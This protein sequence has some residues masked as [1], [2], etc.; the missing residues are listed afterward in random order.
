MAMSR[1]LKHD[2]ELFVE[3]EIEDYKDSI[4]RQSLLRVGDQAIQ[5]LRSKGITELRELDV[6]I[7]VD[8]IIVRRLRLPSFKKW[9]LEHGL[10]QI[11]TSALL[12]SNGNPIGESS[13]PQI[14]QL[15]V[16]ATL[17]DLMA[18][19][20]RTPT[21]LFG[22]SSRQFELVVARLLEKDGFDVEVTPATRDGGKDIIAKLR[23]AAGSFMVYVECKR[24]APDRP[25]GV[26]VIRELVGVV[27]SE[28][29]TAGLVVTTSAFSKPVYKFRDAMPHRL[30]LKAYTDLVEWLSRA[31]GIRREVGV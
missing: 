7:A 29:A 14:L 10:S 13:K 30:D 15:A 31:G 11:R 28:R 5:D 21:D 25:V 16:T 2:Y 22:L 9:R 19:L 12:D 1:S 6:W 17:D 4:S 23:T 20:N 3:R 27:H 24:Y 26:S 8:R 18:G